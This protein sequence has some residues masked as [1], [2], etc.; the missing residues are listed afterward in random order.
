MTQFALRLLAEQRDR[1]ADLLFKDDSERAVLALCGRSRVKDPWSG[2]VDERFLV[3]EII[4]VPEDAYEARSPDGFTW[5][6]TPFFNALKLAEAKDF[7]VAVFH[8]HPAGQLKFSGADD[9]A[10]HDLFQIAFNRLDSDRPHL[11]VI[12]DRTKDLAARVYGP[13]LKPQAASRIMVIGKRWQSWL[14]GPA[15]IAPVELD[16]QARAFGTASSAQIAGL[17]IGLVGCGGTGS[18]IAMLLARIGVRKLALLDDDIVEDTN[19]NRL[20]FATR[21]DAS[22]R[23][24]KVD[25]VGEGAAAIGLPISIIRVPDFADRPAGLAILK[26]CDVVFGCTD[27]DLGREVLNRLAHFYFIPVIDVGLLI[28]PN[29]NGG[30]D[31]FDGRVTVVQPGYPCQSCRGLISNDQ[32][33]QDSLR[34]DPELQEARR[35]AGYV[36][37]DPDPSPVVVTFTTEVA[38]MAVNELFHRLNGF[39]GEEQ[40]CSERV[41]QFQYLKNSD[42]LPSGHSKQGCKICGVRRY[43]GRGDMNPMLDLTL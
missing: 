43:D 20:H 21:I 32:V 35:R 12:M 3:R 34:R 42:T 19:L 27:D 15:A 18:A 7:A 10:E 5:S 16:R 28:E 14:S 38:A 1:I 17:K 41:R 25:V 39:R 23:R 26:A 29:A 24:K 4:E 9:I 11:S 37:N 40:T 6:T 31:I 2:E 13:D 36:P 30:Y 22:L 33:Y 8:A